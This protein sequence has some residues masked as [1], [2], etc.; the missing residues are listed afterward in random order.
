ML[1][2]VE[3]FRLII[4]DSVVV[5]IVNHC[6]LTPEDFVVELGVYRLKQEKRSV[7]FTQLEERLS[8]E[9]H[10]PLFGYTTTYR[11]CLELQ[12][13]QAFSQVPDR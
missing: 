11:C 8:E 9:V 4:V 5:D 1:D 10:H 6:M 13:K 7:F 3:E 2:L 12:V